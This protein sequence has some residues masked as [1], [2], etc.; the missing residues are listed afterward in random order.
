MIEV[1]GDDVQHVCLAD[2]ICSGLKSGIEA[3]IHS[4]TE[5][6][7]SKAH[8]GWGLLLNDAVNGFNLVNRP[9]A[10]WNAR[11]L[12]SRCSKFL[13]NSYRG[14]ALLIIAGS[15]ESLLSRE[16]VTQGDPL[17]M[18]FY[19]L[20]ILPLARKL[21]QPDKWTQNYQE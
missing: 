10:L 11:V 20:A 9:A 4:F 7:N 15:K 21:K 18:L 14:Y 12:W 3:S 8:T 2:Q 19:G 16:G 1:V 17:A 13:F 5:I 6:F